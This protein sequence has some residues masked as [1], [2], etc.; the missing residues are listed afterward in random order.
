MG[1]L[2]LGVV[3]LVVMLEAM[4]HS[5]SL[6]LLLDQPQLLSLLAGQV[7]MDLIFG[8]EMKVSKSKKL[9]FPV[10]HLPDLLHFGLRT[11]G[12]VPDLALLRCAQVQSFD[13]L[14][15]QRVHLGLVRSPFCMSAAMGQS[16]RAEGE[17]QRAKGPGERGEDRSFVDELHDSFLSGNLVSL[18][19]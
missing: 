1:S 9:F 4:L 8:R 7:R 18:M 19:K 5:L 6:V 3:E 17:R 10:R 16:N 12:D 13:H 2:S 14:L 15:E 11:L